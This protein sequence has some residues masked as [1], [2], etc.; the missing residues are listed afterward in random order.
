IRADYVEG[1]RFR[2]EEPAAEQRRG[3]GGGPA[4][5][6]RPVPNPPA[7]APAAVFG[8][9]R[10]GRA[11]ARGGG[12]GGGGAAPARSA[13]RS[14][15]LFS[16]RRSGAARPRPVWPAL[17]QGTCPPRPRRPPRVGPKTCRRRGR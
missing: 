6:P 5:P 8:A 10:P 11:G 2:F 7:V 12:G 16:P 13:P 4:P 14:L 1:S 3:G 9:G 15:L 17:F